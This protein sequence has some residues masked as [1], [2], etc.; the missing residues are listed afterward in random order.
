MNTC[1]T[2]TRPVARR[3]AVVRSVGLEPAYWHRGCWEEWHG[4]LGKPVPA[5]VAFAEVAVVGAASVGW[6]A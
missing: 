6:A 4:P 2:C 3:D 1:Q 5:R